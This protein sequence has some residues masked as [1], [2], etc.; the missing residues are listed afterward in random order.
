MGSK[1]KRVGYVDV[2]RG[3]AMICIVLGHLHVSNINRVV[4]TFHLPIF[5]LISGYFISE[6]SSLS[7]FIKKKFRTLLV[8][9]FITCC[10]MILLAGGIAF[11]TGG[12]TGA[13]TAM[14]GWVWASI[15]GEGDT[16]TTPAF[17]KIIGLLWF[18]WA[19]F[20]G[21]ILLRAALCIKGKGRALFVC[22]IFALGYFSRKIFWLPL[23]I[24]EGCL[25]LLFMYL[26][27]LYKQERS[28]FSDFSKE[29]KCFLKIAACVIWI[30][31]MKD[32]QGFWLVRCFLGRGLIDVIS[33]LCACYC[34]IEIS[35][36]LDIHLPA[37]SGKIEFLGKNS[38]IFM[39]VHNA[40][41]F[42]FPWHMCFEKLTMIGFPG[43]WE[44]AFLIA[45]KLVLDILLTFLL[46]NCNFIRKAYGM[47]KI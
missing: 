38:L 41:Y 47:K 18:L 17:V 9:Y 40:E 24:Q 12:F 34:L 36:I 35:K 11:F 20:W 15:L 14:G 37:I 16:S 7:G 29:T 1:K 22:L 26:G 43:N 6:K 45:G 4:Y 10:V 31:F 27:Y 19:A 42:F 25:A 44:L 28:R 5:F 23:S 33:S 30:G 3:I 2:A 21:S 39:G 8:P 13:K 32:F 46:A